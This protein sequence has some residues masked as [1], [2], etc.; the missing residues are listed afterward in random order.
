ERAAAALEKSLALVRV[1]SKPVGADIF[2][3]RRELGSYG[4]TPK[5]IALPPGEHRIWVESAGHRPSEATVT[6]RRGETVPVELVTER[7]VGRLSVASPVAG[8][9]SVRSATGETLQEGATPLEANVPPGS[10]EVTVTAAGHLPWS[11][12]AHVGAD[13]STTV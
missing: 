1:A 9:A 3:D 4:R 5:V 2:V 12:V 7:I 8:R 6:A 10:Y 11:G 13:E